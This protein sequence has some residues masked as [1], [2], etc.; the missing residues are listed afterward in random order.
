MLFIVLKTPYVGGFSLRIVMREEG[1]P[2]FSSDDS[3]ITVYAS[4]AAALKAHPEL[5]LGDVVYIESDIG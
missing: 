4:R 2:F 1:Q 3:V 5:E